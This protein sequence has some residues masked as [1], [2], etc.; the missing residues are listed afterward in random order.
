[1]AEEMV[2][3]IVLEGID[4]ASDDIERTSGKTKGLGNEFD[5]ATLKAAGLL[6]AVNGLASGL[7]QVSGGMRKTADAG[8]RAGYINEQNAEKMRGWADTMEFVAGPLEMIAGLANFFA[9]IVIINKLMP[10]L[11]LASK[12]LR[13]LGIAAAIGSAPI[14]GTV[15]IVTALTGA[16]VLLG[17][18]VFMH[19]DKIRGLSHEYINFGGRVEW[20]TRKFGEA[21]DAVDGFND[22]V[23]SFSVDNIKDRIGDEI[24]GIGGRLGLG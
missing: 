2:L 18:A 17:V 19:R 16:L 4:N 8:E 11:G 15:L 7:N 13:V 1:M 5:T 12:A 24:S 14:T 3:R 10:A 22:A 9:S 6:L 23:G 20:V 21:K